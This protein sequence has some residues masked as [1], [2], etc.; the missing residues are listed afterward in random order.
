MS[1]SSAPTTVRQLVPLCYVQDISASVAFY[2]RVLDFRPT[3]AWQPEGKLTWCQLERDAAAI[4]LQRMSSQDKFAGPRGEGVTFYFHCDD[5]EDVYR[6]L[7][8]RGVAVEPPFV[9]FYGMKQVFVADPDG[10]RLCFQNPCD[11][12]PSECVVPD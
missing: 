7:V 6:R 3:H 12:A 5:A 2:V 11:P 8:E 1:T 10:Y 9:T 4:M